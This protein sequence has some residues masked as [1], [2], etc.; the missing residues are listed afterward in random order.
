MKD[1][2]TPKIL[3]VASGGGHWIQLLRL[4][5]AFAGAEVVYASTSPGSDM[6]RLGAPYHELRDANRDTKLALLLSAAQ[7]LGV[8]LRERPDVVVT[9][10]AAPGYFAVLFGRLLGARTLWIDSIANAGRISASGA[11]ARR[12][13]SLFLT[14]W[15]A[16]ATADGI[17]YEGT[18]L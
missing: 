2:R 15:E 1:S 18:V 12:H 11:L 16:L 17:R 10:G 9:T 4:R 8:V 6:T 7:V 3:A 14:Q 5:P 13:A